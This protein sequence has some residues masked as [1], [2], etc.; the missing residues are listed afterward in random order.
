MRRPLA[1]CLLSRHALEPVHCECALAE[2][3]D[4]RSMGVQLEPPLAATVH[5]PCCR[6]P[7]SCCTLS[8]HPTIHT[9][10]QQLTTMIEYPLKCVSKR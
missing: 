3:P 5:N 7:T 10:H 9:G 6:S 2:R 8:A 1:H 4:C